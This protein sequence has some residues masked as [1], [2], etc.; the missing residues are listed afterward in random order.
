M[1]FMNIHI[2][3]FSRGVN[4]LLLFTAALCVAQSAMAAFLEL[5]P[6]NAGDFTYVESPTPS[7][8][9][10]LRAS[11]K[12]PLVEANYFADEAVAFKDAGKEEP[13]GKGSGKPGGVTDQVLM[14]LVNKIDLLVSTLRTKHADAT[15]D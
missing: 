9:A 3:T 10:E 13:K 8:V 1:I 14:S 6:G 15:E 5:S 11:G 2:R 7:A 12:R 4:A